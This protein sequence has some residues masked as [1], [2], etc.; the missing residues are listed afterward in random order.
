MGIKYSSKG[1]IPFTSKWVLK[2]KT[3]LDGTIDKFKIRLVV[4]RFSKIHGVDN[5]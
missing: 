4:E 1:R 5:T 3:K 2:I